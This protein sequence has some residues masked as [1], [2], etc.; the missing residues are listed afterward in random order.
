M[1]IATFNI[2]NLFHRD[3]SL[4]NIQA[5][6]AVF[7]W[8]DEMEY[9]M[10]KQSKTASDLDTIK[11]LSFLLG[12]DKI[13]NI[14]YAIMRRRIEAMFFR[15]IHSSGE[16]EANCLTDF[17]GW[18]KLQTLP[19]DPIATQNKARVIAEV[20]ADVLLLQEVENR[21]SLLEFNNQ[22]LQEFNGVPYRELLV[23]QGNDGRG[24]EIGMLTKNGFQIQEVR[25]YSNEL[26]DSEKPVFEKNLLKYEIT[27]PSKNKIYLLAVH[28]QEQGKD[29]ENCDALRFRQARRV[30]EI[31]RQL[32]DQ[33]QKYV[34]V[35]GILNAVPYCF[36][37][38][39]LLQK[40]DLKDV[41][42]HSS[43]NVA[44]EK[45]KD[46]GYLHMNAYRMG[47]NIKQRDYLLLSP[48]MFRRVKNSGL[49]RN[50]IWPAIASQWPV[51]DTIK[52]EKQAVSEHP[53]VW[54]EI[55]I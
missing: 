17:N 11:D 21:N 52:N 47:L 29:K 39:P 51:C 6:E 38:A 16:T 1:K 36:S 41:S 10:N 32:L 46:A 20:N 40:T 48:E 22:F 44:G 7:N 28:L 50:A 34:I 5:G 18:V 49:N 27:T 53:V 25:T 37:L 31:Y 13:S 2:Q 24:Q 55:E 26:D 14:S 42:K 30:A 33:G 43:F 15:A 54:G 45:E 12:F 8:L 23:L 19:V 9:L 3:K 35:A 4:V